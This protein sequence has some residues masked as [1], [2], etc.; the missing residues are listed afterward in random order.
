[1][2]NSKSTEKSII[3]KIILDDAIDRSYEKNGLERIQEGVERIEKTLDIS[4]NMISGAITGSEG[5]LELGRM[6][7]LVSEDR[8][9]EIERKSREVGDEI[10]DLLCMVEAYEKIV[11]LEE[12]N[13]N[14]VEKT[15]IELEKIYG[16]QS[17]ANGFEKIFGGVMETLGKKTNRDAKPW[18]PPSIKVPEIKHSRDLEM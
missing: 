6:D 7:E 14:G 10:E 5:N 12:R 8:N 3:H 15:V 18:V 16:I 9:T 2:E 13:M 4:E 11:D 17:K 1:M